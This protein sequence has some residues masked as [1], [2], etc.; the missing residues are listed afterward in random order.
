MAGCSFKGAAGQGDGDG[1]RDAAADGPDIGTDANPI[2]NPITLNLLLNGQELTD[3]SNL[4]RL[5]VGDSINLN[6]G[7]SCSPTGN[8]TFSWSFDA[9]D[10]VN[11]GNVT[12]QFFIELYPD[13]PGVRTVTITI[14]DG[15]DQISQP[16]SFNS[17]GFRPLDIDDD[18]VTDVDVREIALSNDAVWLATDSGALTRALDMLDQVPYPDVNSTI[19]MPTA[20][21]AADVSDVAYDPDGNFV[22]F[23][24][25]DGTTV[26]FVDRNGDDITSR[27]SDETADLGNYEDAAH[28]AGGGVRL[29]TTLQSE[30]TTNYTDDFAKDWTRDLAQAIGAQ[31]NDVLALGQRLYRQVNMT[32][33]DER[34]LF[35]NMDDD[36]LATMF[37][38]SD[39]AL[40]IGST[41]GNA[42]TGIAVIDDF[43][44]MSIE[45]HLLGESIRA[46]GQDAAGDMWVAT[47]TGVHRFKSDWGIWIQLGTKHGLIDV[48]A[49]S[50][51]VDEGGGRNQLLVGTAVD[52]HRLNRP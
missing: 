24:R 48:D 35:G 11:R 4:P 25:A 32:M 23:I 50:L 3:P 36:G 10:Y 16:L 30:T 18:D 5:T 6:A 9:N 40:W 39:G 43:M 13:N 12:N 52:L 51:V 38:D 2:C 14:D 34:E 20:T 1:D 45:E 41:A 31:G 17:V 44:D 42:D 28:M 22:T 26:F 37:I 15:T 7:R 33:S 49:K 21:I 19:N 29:L 47:A 27:G 46:I 8:L